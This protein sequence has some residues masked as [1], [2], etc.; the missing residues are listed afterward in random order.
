MFGIGTWEFMLILILALVVLGPSRLPDLAKSLGRG[1][2]EFRRASQE[3]RDS[4]SGDADLGDLK[5][6]I[7]DTR[8]EL[9]EDFS[10][11]D[12]TRIEG[13]EQVDSD[14][15]EDRGLS[16]DQERESTEERSPVE[17]EGGSSDSAAAQEEG[18]DAGRVS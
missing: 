15:E 7:E 4:L 3:L 8:H 10:I 5:D 16:S 18:G 6:I 1:Y 13:V 2:N 17:P 9:E 12:D 14:D 11:D